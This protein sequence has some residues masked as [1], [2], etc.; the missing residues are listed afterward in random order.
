MKPLLSVVQ[1]LDLSDNDMHRYDLVELLS[2]VR[3]STRLRTLHLPD[4]S[5]QSVD[6][7]ACEVAALPY[8]E[9]VGGAPLTHVLAKPYGA[10]WVLAQPADWR[11]RTGAASDERG[12]H[13]CCVSNGRLSRG[14][15][16][17]AWRI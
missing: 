6:G 17:G 10:G 1:E 16:A 4:L 14:Q 9:E 7:V 5:C 3:S 2:S 8:L 15:G 13:R 12:L 11:G